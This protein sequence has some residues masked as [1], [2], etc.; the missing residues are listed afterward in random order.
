MTD[1]L[2]RIE[3]FSE[4]DA[5]ALGK[6]WIEVYRPAGH[7]DN[8]IGKFVAIWHSEEGLEELARLCGNYRRVGI[9]KVD[10][11][12]RDLTPILNSMVKKYNVKLHGLGIT[13]M[14]AMREIKWE[15]VGSTTWLAP[16]QWGESHIWTGRELKRYPKKYSE[17]ARKQ[18]RQLFMNNGFD[19]AKISD[20]DT[21]ELLK[22]SVWS[23]Q[24]FADSIGTAVVTKL[25]DSG[26]A[27]NSENGIL[28]VM[29]PE[30]RTDNRLVTQTESRHV[31][32]PT[33]RQTTSLPIMGISVRKDD[34]SDQEMPF[35][36]KRSDSMRV[37]NSCFLRD[38]CPGF[39]SDANC[40]YNIPIEIKTNDQLRALQDAL[41]TMQA[42]RVLFMQMAEDMEGGYAD[43]NLSSEIDRLQRLI[44]ARNE[45]ERTGF[46]VNVSASEPGV[47]SRIFGSDAGMR[48]QSI[49]PVKADSLINKAMIYDAEIV[50]PKHV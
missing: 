49:E 13:S 43:P 19:A 36:H 23:W 17:R 9:L 39:E 15:S 12:D 2:D 18:H 21:N 6:D 32:I 24:H 50:E 11:F 1:N 25:P 8:L 46:S 10:A 29:T 20:G 22:L 33:Q 3:I 26:N 4:F 7:N 35:L 37:C 30:N 31:L 45:A 40:L 47:I 34:E 38:K 5:L 42:Q 28:A 44:K 41:I 48:A 27:E 14:E 16:I